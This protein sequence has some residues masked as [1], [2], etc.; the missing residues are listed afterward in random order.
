MT[1]TEEFAEYLK[2]MKGKQIKI[3]YADGATFSP[4]VGSLCPVHVPA[5]EIA[6]GKWSDARDTIE[7]TLISHGGVCIE[8]LFDAFT[9]ANSEAA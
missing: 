4:Y 3:T 6:H 7:V 8:I 5:I 9:R 1:T 2:G